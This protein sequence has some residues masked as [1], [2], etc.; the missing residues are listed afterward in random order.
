M[1]NPGIDMEIWNQ[2]KEKWAALDAKGYRIKVDFNLLADPQDE[3]N[4]LAIDVVQHINDREIVV[5]TVQHIPGEAYGVLGIA[6]LSIERL[7]EV[8]QGMMQDLYQQ[9]RPKGFEMDLSLTMSPHSAASG[10]VEAL[11]VHPDAPVQSWV[12][13]NY[14]YYYV[15]NALREKMAEVNGQRWKTVRVEYHAGDLQFYF[16]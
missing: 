11:L 1:N 10:E 5:E 7:K 16:K 13:V 14:R 2:L 8:L 15:L 3:K 4:I 6:E 12:P 9:T